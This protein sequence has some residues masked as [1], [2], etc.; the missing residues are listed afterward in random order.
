MFNLKKHLEDKAKSAMTDLRTRIEERRNEV[1]EKIL[2][3]DMFAN[4]VRY[5]GADALPQVSPKAAVP[6]PDP[7][8]Q[9]SVT[10]HACARLHLPGG[11]RVSKTQVH[12][13]V[14]DT[15]GKT[16]E[17][18]S[19][20]G[21]AHMDE[22]FEFLVAD[23][24]ANVRVLVY[25]FNVLAP[26]ALLGQVI[27]PL[28]RLLPVPARSVP[29]PQRLCET[30]WYE[31]F[32]LHGDC[33]E[34]RPAVADVAGTG[35][36]RA[37]KTLGYV[38]LTVKMEPLA[39]VHDERDWPWR[40]YASRPP[41]V[42]AKPETV[43]SLAP[44]LPRT[45]RHL[46]RQAHRLRALGNQ[47]GSFA[48][49]AVAVRT[50]AWTDPVFS[51]AVL[52]CAAVIVLVAPVWALPLCA[53][54]LVAA[55]SWLCHGEVN[56]E[57]R[58]VM[59]NDEI[60]DPDELLNPVQLMS[61]VIDILETVSNVLARL[62]DA[63]ERALHLF[64]FRDERVSA[65]ALALSAAAAS[66]VALVLWL[67]VERYL[68]A[69]ALIVACGP[70]GTLASMRR[71]ER[72]VPKPVVA[73]SNVLSRSPTSEY[74]AHL[75]ICELQRVKDGAVLGELLTALAESKSAHVDKDVDTRSSRASSES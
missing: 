43:V 30:G 58:F 56:P 17:H 46:K 75:A 50:L 33:V 38:W 19:K 41:T 65:S 29:T 68:I 63:L 61:K 34:F 40:A 14:E 37:S 4:H 39:E 52:S 12:V 45:V 25:Q 57:L 6:V 36:Q 15:K 60:F 9:V 26:D 5:P 47:A 7:V 44:D 71:P 8:A 51:S 3:S 2:R 69:L 20:K 74:V 54:A 53:V 59:Y 21:V 1:T 32:P 55:G 11:S 42:P 24:A 31:I 67:G 62:A 16:E 23:C 70:A 72:P 13:V 18:T 64:S 66:V 22:S 73:A 48:P 28:R 49:T 27:V 10:V 35:M